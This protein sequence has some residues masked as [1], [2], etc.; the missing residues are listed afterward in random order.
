MYEKDWKKKSN[1]PTAKKGSKKANTANQNFAQLSKK[2]DKLENVLKKLSK[3]V[4][5]AD[6]RIAI[7]TTNRE[8]G[9][10]ALGN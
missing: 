4:Q 8:L 9:Q 1:F 5:S 6:M 7:W 10:V 3:K 2:L